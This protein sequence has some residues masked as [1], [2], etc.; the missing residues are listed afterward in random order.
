MNNKID[1]L[2]VLAERMAGLTF[3]RIFIK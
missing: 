1:V 2:A 3:Y